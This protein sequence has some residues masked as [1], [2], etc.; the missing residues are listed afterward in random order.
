MPISELRLTP[1]TKKISSIDRWS[2]PNVK[3][4]CIPDGTIKLEWEI[5]SQSVKTLERRGLITA[6]EFRVGTRGRFPIKYEISEYGM[7]PQLF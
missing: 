3:T 4:K 1:V 6:I 7:T 2:Y 5:D